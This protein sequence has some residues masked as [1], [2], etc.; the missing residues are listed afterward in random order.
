L[1]DTVKVGR[2]T[3]PALFVAC[4]ALNV[5]MTLN[6]NAVFMDPFFAMLRPPA[7]ERDAARLCLNVPPECSAALETVPKLHTLGCNVHDNGPNYPLNRSDFSYAL[8]Y[9]P[10]MHRSTCQGIARQTESSDTRCLLVEPRHAETWVLGPLDGCAT[11]GDV[12]AGHVRGIYVIKREQALGDRASAGWHA[13]G[14]C[15]VG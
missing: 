12:L 7:L 4:S 9:V 11:R 1:G 14:D 13:G 8:T 5:A 15:M 10:M 6:N 3:F 2:V